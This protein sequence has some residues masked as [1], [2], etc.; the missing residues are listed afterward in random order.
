MRLISKLTAG[1][2]PIG[3]NL[4][5]LGISHNQPPSFDSYP[6][7]FNPKARS[8]WVEVLE[9]E[10]YATLLEECGDRLPIL[11]L[12]TLHLWLDE[13]SK[14]GVWPFSSRPKDDTDHK[15]FLA[16]ERNKIVKWLDSQAWTKYISVFST[17]TRFLF[18][19]RNF[20][21]T[22]KAKLAPIADPTLGAALLKAGFSRAGD[23][24]YTYVV[25][26]HSHVTVSLGADPFL[27]YAILC[28]T[29]LVKSDTLTQHNWA[30]KEWAAVVRSNPFF[31]TNRSF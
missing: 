3:V 9:S 12:K 7:K 13:C 23:S 31:F 1:F 22:A 18:G 27:E 30:L 25:H 20:T 2:D 19:N 29:Q 24:L 14:E 15:I 8:A 10:Q 5:P 21:V 26:G 28:P 4:S 16:I 6:A 17:A 11:W